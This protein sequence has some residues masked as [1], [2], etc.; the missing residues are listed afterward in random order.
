[1]ATITGY[2]VYTESWRGWREPTNSNPF[3]N[4]NNVGPYDGNKHARTVIR[5]DL[6]A[7]ASNYI[8]DKLTIS[9]TLSIPSTST[10]FNSKEKFVA[11]LT[12][13][14]DGSG[15]TPDSSSY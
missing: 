10:T 7:I 2:N 15:Y 9:T 11:V 6:A 12:N 14:F 8:R 1:M 4:Y 3:T 5:I 13:N